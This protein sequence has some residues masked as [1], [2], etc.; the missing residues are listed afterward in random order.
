MTWR[1]EWCHISRLRDTGG[2]A[3]PESLGGSASWPRAGAGRA[4]FTGDASFGSGYR[5]C[6]GEQLMVQ[7]TAGLPGIVCERGLTLRRLAREAGGGQL[8]AGSGTVTVEVRGT[9]GAREPGRRRPR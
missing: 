9:A 3:C 2:S 6:A 7:V 4:R 1:E 5:R 8:P